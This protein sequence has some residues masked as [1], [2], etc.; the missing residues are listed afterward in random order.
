MNKINTDLSEKLKLLK[1]STS[2]FVDIMDGLKT[3]GAVRD[4]QDLNAL[5][6]PVIATNLTPTDT[7]GAYYVSETGGSCQIEQTTIHTSDLIVADINGVVVIP[8]R[9]IDA[10]I[11]KALEITE[12]ENNMLDKIRRGER[13]PDLISVTGRI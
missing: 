2:T 12:V 1:I 11:S 4:G 8:Y 3:G 13:L 5:S 9:D 10:V 6:I 7:Q